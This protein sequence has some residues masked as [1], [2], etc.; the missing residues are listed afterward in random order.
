M[1]LGLEF[2]LVNILFFIQSTCAGKLQLNIEMFKWLMTIHFYSNYYF[3]L[4]YKYPGRKMK[5]G[6]VL[7]HYN[8]LYDH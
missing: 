2:G 8:C 4:S 7:M 5:E 3:L 6:G 1:V